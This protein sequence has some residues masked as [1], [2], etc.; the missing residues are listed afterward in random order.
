MQGF[1][2]MYILICALIGT[3]LTT[4]AYVAPSVRDIR[5]AEDCAGTVFRLNIVK[6]AK[7]VS[8]VASILCFAS[9]NV[10]GKLALTKQEM[11][12]PA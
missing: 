6:R 4:R 10:V 2:G 12:G 9:S 8:Q 7:S 11:Q 5:M 3:R 1:P